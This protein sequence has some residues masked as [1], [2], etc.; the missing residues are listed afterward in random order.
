[1]CVGVLAAPPFPG[2]APCPPAPH[3]PRHTLTHRRQGCELGLP[4]AN[5]PWPQM[6]ASTRA[7]ASAYATDFDAA[8][9][10]SGFAAAPQHGGWV[11]SCLV[12]CDAG[13]GAWSHTLAQPR[14]GS[15]PALTP[16]AAFEAWRA[17]GAGAG[18]GWWSDRSATPNM[19][20]T[21]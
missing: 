11:S 16:S 18:D 15:G 14:S 2:T 8:L 20:A 12:H 7:A 10:A 6:A 21:C 9:A 1:M 5:K 3:A 19:T 13:D 17:G 4:D